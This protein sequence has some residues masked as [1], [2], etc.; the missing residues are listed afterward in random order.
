MKASAFL[1]VAIACILTGC[2]LSPNGAIAPQS[3]STHKATDESDHTQ[4]NAIVKGVLDG[5]FKAV[6][7][8]ADANSDGSLSQA[9]YAKGHDAELTTLFM[10]QFDGNK[11]GQ[12]TAAE[13]KA[14]LKG[15]AAIE[16]Y[17]HL[18][19]ARMEKA[20]ARVAGQGGFGFAQMR[21]YLT[22]ELGSSG[23]FLLI[24]KLM[25]RVDLNKD[26]KV[27]SDP[28]EGPAFMILFAQAQLEH[29]LG[30]PLSPISA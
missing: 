5:Q 25:G 23:D 6:V 20:V 2:G 11:D 10:A 15:T 4:M 27:F 13:Y 28:K 29:V 22:Q 12:V 26:G 9:E 19:E 3:T 17:H 18:T 16:A 21:T 14:A 7:A 8:D 30:L 24:S 1:A